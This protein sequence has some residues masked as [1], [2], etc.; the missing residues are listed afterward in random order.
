VSCPRLAE[1]NAYVPVNILPGNLTPDKLAPFKVVVFSHAPLP[2]LLEMN[3]YTHERGIAFIS[4]STHG[5]FGSLFCD[6]GPS[7]LVVD[8]NGENPITGMISSITPDG[9]VTMME[10][11]RHG[12]E[13]GDTIVFQEVDG[14]DVNEREFKVEVKTADTFSI[15]PVDF[16][17][18]YKQGGIFTQV[19]VTKEYKFVSSP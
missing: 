6:F 5:L 19:K 4:T 15:G 7:F 14:L 11:G 13:D 1:L 3:D 10:E 18:T 9:L 2:T 12:L 17:G 16:L 8:Q